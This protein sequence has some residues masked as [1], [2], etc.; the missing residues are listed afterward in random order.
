MVNFGPLAAGGVGEWG[1]RADGEREGRRLGEGRRR[2]RHRRRVPV[3][4]DEARF[5]LFLFLPEL[6][7]LGIE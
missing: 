6:R 5:Q 1:R 4:E 7:E 3:E 2:W